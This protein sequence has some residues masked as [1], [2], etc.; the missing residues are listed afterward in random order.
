MR[1]GRRRIRGGVYLVDGLV[2]NAYYAFTYGGVYPFRAALF[3]VLLG[4]KYGKGMIYKTG[5][6]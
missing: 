1:C 3:K 2:H 6:N 4:L 5:Y